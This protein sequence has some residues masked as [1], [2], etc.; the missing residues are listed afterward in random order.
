MFGKNIDWIGSGGVGLYEKVNALDYN[1]VDC[2]YIKDMFNYG[3]ILMVLFYF[4][5]Y[6][7]FIVILFRE[8]KRKN[9]SVIHRIKDM[10]IRDEKIY[11]ITQGDNNTVEDADPVEEKQVQGKVIASIPYIA[12]PTIWINQN[13]SAA[14]IDIE[15]G[16]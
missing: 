6:F 10:Y 5:C 8:Y 4:H 3:I 16:K 12:Y 11:I 2:S 1:F 13:R 7:I 14:D 15:L 9:F